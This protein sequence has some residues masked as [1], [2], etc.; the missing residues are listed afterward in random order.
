MIQAI[1][2]NDIKTVKRLLKEGTQMP[3]GDYSYTPIDIAV[4]NDN[5]EMLS[6]LLANGAD[7]KWDIEAMKTALMTC[8]MKMVSLLVEHGY[9]VK[10][11]RNYGPYDPL[12]CST[13]SETIFILHVI[14]AVF[15]AS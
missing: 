7:P 4:R 8:N 3:S 2:K 6:F 12:P 14:S 11:D 10:G 13:R 1:T 9:Q 15:M 5:S